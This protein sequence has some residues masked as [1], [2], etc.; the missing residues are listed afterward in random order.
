VTVIAVIALLVPHILE[1]DRGLSVEARF[2]LRTSGC[3]C[4]REAHQRLG[5]EEV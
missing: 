2:R 1:G 3:L 4:E 5:Y